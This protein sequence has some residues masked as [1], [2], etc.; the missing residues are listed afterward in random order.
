MKTT[1][2]IFGITG[3]LSTRKL[4]PALS[5]IIGNG[6]FDDISIIGVSRRHVEQYALLGDHHEQLNGTTAMFTMDMT[7]PEEYGRLRDY[8][9]LQDDEQ[10]IIYLSVPPSSS[11]GIVEQ[12]GHAGMNGTNVKLLLEKPFG[13]D[14]ASAR[15]MIEHVSQ[16]YHESQVYRIDHYLAKEMAQNILI[17][18]ASNAIFNTIWDN[19][20]I[21]HIEIIASEQLEIENRAAFYEETGA[22][23]D[24]L[25][26]HLM[27][28]LALTIMDLPDTI[29]W[30][31]LPA[32]R[33]EAVSHLLPAN[34]D[35]AIRG[36]YEGYADIVGNPQSRTETFVAVS[37]SS[38]DEKWRGVTMRL[39]T[40]KA[41]KEKLTEVRV[42]FKKQR[43]T[44]ANTLIF[45]IQPDE[46]VELDVYARKPG[47]DGGYEL[48]KLRFDYTHDEKLPD[49][50]EQ[51]LVDAIRSHKSLF[52]GSD[53]VIRAWEILKP[54]QDAW[55]A[56]GD[57]PQRYEKG[58]DIR[59]IVA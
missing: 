13:T 31:N 54:V 34:S 22:L 47:Y 51:V 2:V 44:Q 7:Q 15:S 42:H 46:G 45:S 26:G 38:N 12:L 28:L 58:T 33:L 25:Q 55:A 1:L 21:E 48:K 52:A 6:E 35:L 27:Q 59:N 4:L 18:R 57:L 19:R 40:G 32:G 14:L 20:F 37:L 9:D 43:D 36:Q 56:T 17:F 29:H 3:D 50:Y 8:I 5:R 24:V 11:A 16:Y 30:D 49:A 23:R 53:E 10:A 41:L 39:A